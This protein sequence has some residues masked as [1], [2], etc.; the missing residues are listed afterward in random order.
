[1]IA[2]YTTLKTLNNINLLKL[3]TNP[4]LL[5][6]TTWVHKLIPK[7]SQH[8]CGHLCKPRPKIQTQLQGVS[9]LVGHQ[10][11]PTPASTLASLLPFPTHSIHR[12]FVDFPHCY[13][14]NTSTKKEFE[15][16]TLKE[17][18]LAISQPN[19]FPSLFICPLLV[20]LFLLLER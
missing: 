17:R 8:S 11:A 19:S 6:T 16:Q 1:M 13:Y 7:I 4:F 3:S 10:I 14:S 12:I 5:C 9:S 20:L 18:N 2:N 15:S